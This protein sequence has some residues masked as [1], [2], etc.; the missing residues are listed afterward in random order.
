MNNFITALQFFTRIRLRRQQEWADDAFSRSV[1]WFTPV[2]AVIGLLLSCLSMLLAPFNSLLRAAVLLAAEIFIT[3]ATLNDGL[4]DTADGVFAGRGRARA[5]EIMK[6]SRVGANGVIAFVTVALLKVAVYNALAE[7]LLPCA[8]FAM[9]IVTRLAIAFAVTHFASARPD[10]IGVLFA[11]YAQKSCALKAALFAV[12][13]LIPVFSWQLAAASAICLAY[14]FFA[15]RRL[16]KMLGGLT[17]DTYGFIA[18][19]GSVVFLFST[20]LAS[21]LQIKMAWS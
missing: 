2:G 8:V 7:E 13:L 4:L 18:E 21:L 15:A 9:P 12:L 19:T 5:L 6:D 20:Y 16:N 14:S 11:K 10:G 3:G 17:G 1:P